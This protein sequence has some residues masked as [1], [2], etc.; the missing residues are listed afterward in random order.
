M[1]HG[2]NII[3]AQ[4]LADFPPQA[5]TGAVQMRAMHVA[6]LKGCDQVVAK[7]GFASINIMLRRP[8]ADGEGHG[9]L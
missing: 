2:R 9:T 8:E 1:L 6:M 4:P 5:I 3:D 7:W